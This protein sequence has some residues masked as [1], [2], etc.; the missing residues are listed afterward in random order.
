MIFNDLSDI[1]YYN[2]ALKGVPRV[3]PKKFEDDYI[4]GQTKEHT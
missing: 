4:T 3:S 1:G 2:E